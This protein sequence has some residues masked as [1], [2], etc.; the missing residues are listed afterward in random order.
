MRE[1]AGRGLLML[2][3]PYL[4]SRCVQIRWASRSSDGV[5]EELS[6]M[7]QVHEQGKLSR[8]MS[9]FIVSGPSPAPPPM[10]HF[11]HAASCIRKVCHVIAGVVRREWVL[12]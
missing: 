3:E 10:F 11:F 4:V 12:F 6:W 2:I 9:E 1:L 5:G 7:Q 8:V